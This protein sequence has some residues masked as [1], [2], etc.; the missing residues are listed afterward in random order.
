VNGLYISGETG[1][2]KTHLLHAL[3]DHPHA[4]YIP[5]TAPEEAFDFTESVCIWSMTATSCH[6]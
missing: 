6:D 1:A 4:R 3:A 5:A 2:G